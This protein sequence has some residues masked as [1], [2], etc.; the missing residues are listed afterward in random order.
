MLS[1]NLPQRSRKIVPSVIAVL[2]IALV[3]LPAQ[4]Q[5]PNKETPTTFTSKDVFAIPT[6]NGNINFGFNGSYQEAKLE[7]NTWIFKGLE[8]NNTQATAAYGFPDVESIRDLQISAQ[9]SNVTV[10]GCVSFSYSWTA[11]VIMY[12]VEGYGIQIVNVGIN[13][14]ERTSAD[15]W[16]VLVDNGATFLAEGSGWNLRRDNSVQV[17]VGGGNVT[18]MHF[19]FNDPSMTNLSFMMQHYVAVL[20]VV[21]LAVVMVLAAVIAVRTRRRK[22][23]PNQTLG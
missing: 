12:T 23:L 4:A 21:V 8:L 19:D 17:N 14:T 10:W 20:T 18:V 9:D 15:E 3:V 2:L 16:S 7:N 6:L 11:Q 22:R 5:E 13:A 1:E